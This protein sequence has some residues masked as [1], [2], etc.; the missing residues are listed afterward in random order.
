MPAISRAT[1]RGK[2]AY[3]C[4]T[5]PRPSLL[6]NRPKARRSPG[7]ESDLRGLLQPPQGRGLDAN[8]YHKGEQTG[9]LDIVQLAH[10]VPRYR[11]RFRRDAPHKPF[12]IATFVHGQTD[13]PDVAEGSAVHRVLEALT[14]WTRTGPKCRLI[15]RRWHRQGSPFTG[16]AKM[17]LSTP[18]Q[19]GVQ[20]GCRE[21][22]AGASGRSTTTI[23]LSSEFDACEFASNELGECVDLVA[24]RHQRGERVPPLLLQRAREAAYVLDRLGT[25]DPK[26]TYRT[27][28][29]PTRKLR[30]QTGKPQSPASR[31]EYVVAL[32]DRLSGTIEPFCESREFHGRFKNFIRGIVTAQIHE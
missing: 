8:A 22:S 12:T 14:G 19:T 25:G 10:G 21:N 13:M 31:T 32:G 24:G 30:L 18:A 6:W 26:A 16:R 23:L 4:A 7:S 11:Y 15:M 2:A 1:T 27:M 3:R 28:K 20:S 17:T 5:R 9:W 29:A